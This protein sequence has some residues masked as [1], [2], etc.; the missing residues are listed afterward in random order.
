MVNQPLPDGQHPSHSDEHG[1]AFRAVRRAISGGDR[2]AISLVWW[3]VLAIVL[4]GVAGLADRAEISR[5]LTGLCYLACYLVS[6]RQPAR[7][8][9]RAARER[10]LTV[11]QLMV[12]A[13]VGAAAIGQVFDGALLM[14]IFATTG[15]LEAVATARTADSVRRLLRLAPDR[16]TR[17]LPGGSQETVDTAALRIGDV[18]LVHPGER[19]GADGTVLDGFSEVDQASITGEPL[20]VAKEPGDEVFAGT[21]NGGGALRV[22]VHR[23]AEESV[24]ARIVAMAE[25]ASTTKANTQVFIERVE[26]RYSVAVVTI[27][28]SLLCIPVALGEA[29]EPALLRALAFMIV[30]SPCAVVLATM[31]PL[32]SSI[33]NA[34]RHGVLVKSAVVMEQLGTTTV[35]AFD[36]TG[37]LTEGT[38]RVTDVVPLDETQIGGHDLV[39]LAAAAEGSSDHP[40]ARAIVA[41]ARDWRVAVPQAEDSH[42]RPGRGVSALVG[43]RRV[44]VGSP[45]MLTDRTDPS[46]EQSISTVEEMG[47]TAVVVLVDGRPVGILGLADQPRPDAR[48]TTES[49]RRLTGGE[50]VLLTGDNIGAARWV[51]QESGITEVHSGLLPADKVDIIRGLQESGQRVAFVGDGVNDAPA[52]ATADIGIAMSHVG[53]IWRCT[54]PMWLS[55]ATSS[56][57]C[58]R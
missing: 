14:V 35:V 6:G 56:P 34:S 8:G 11:D 30:A 37:T 17:I 20:P 41:A 44:F 54:V 40:L 47:R 9:L 27:A 3:A 23:P 42:S 16:A 33:A 26:Q 21:L 15:A 55:C 49:L 22:E 4:L 31:P 43:G 39:A 38:P 12:V 7:A 10:V 36:K 46:V 25:Q 24:V 1:D 2:W 50:S 13:A 19:V 51:G 57:L 48:R 53:R 29:L 5:P 32:L 52:L 58:R 18:V 28:L 45:A